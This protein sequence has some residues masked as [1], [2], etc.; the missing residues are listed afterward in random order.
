MMLFFGRML[1]IAILLW[2]GTK[3]VALA[4]PARTYLD[5]ALAAMGG[6]E[7]LLALKSQRVVSHGENFEPEQSLRPGAEPRKVSTFSCTLVRDLNSGQVRYDWQRESV[8]P[9]ALSWRYTEILNGDQ[10]AI[11]GTDGARSP[12]QRPASSIRM[13]ARRKELSRAPV[14]ILLN[15]L[16]RAGSLFRLMDQTIRGRLNDVV[17]F[18]DGGLFVV[19]AIDDQ[20]RLLTKVEFLDDDPVYGDVQN[21]LFLDDWRQVG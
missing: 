20:T 2:C 16:A 5:T 6:R 17:S 10:G 12:A 18:D 14:S 4:Q 3:S 1:F 13:A 15:A 21:E 8:D 9:F 11:I 7:T 19:M